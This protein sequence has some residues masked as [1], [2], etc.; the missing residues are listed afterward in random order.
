[1]WIFNFNSLFREY[2]WQFLLRIGLPHPIRTASAVLRSGSVDF[3]RTPVAVPDPAAAAHFPDAKALVGAG[4]CLK[5]LDPP[6][7]SGRFNHDCQWLERL[8]GPDGA[9]IPDSCRSCVLRELGLLALKTGSAFYIMTSARDILLDLYEPALKKGRFSTVLLVLCRYSLK[10]FSV[11]L[12]ASRLKG[13]LFPF[14]DGDCADYKT[15]IRADKGIKT[16]QTTLTADNLAAIRELL[17]KAARPGDA[18]ACFHKRD[19]IFH[20]GARP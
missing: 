6:C 13:W 19:N 1:M 15:W 18:P 9:P 3:T 2:G 7:P 8:P 14:K 11:G 20:A 5:P 10:P 16:E 17:T 4:F 12:L